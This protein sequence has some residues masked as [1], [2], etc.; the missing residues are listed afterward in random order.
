MKLK[1]SSQEYLDKAAALSKE[2]AE[3]LFARMRGKL[4]RK[5]ENEKIPSL[6]AVALQLQIEDE[7]LQEWR[8]RWAE[9][10]QREAARTKKGD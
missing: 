4:S 1:L 5:V 10:E 3:R 2:D 9:I 8:Q 6:E 7:E